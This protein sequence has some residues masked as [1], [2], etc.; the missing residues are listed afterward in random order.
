MREQRNRG[1]PKSRNRKF[2]IQT[3]LQWI[4]KSVDLDYGCPLKKFPTVKIFQTCFKDIQN[5][6]MDKNI[7]IYLNS[8]QVFSFSVLIHSIFIMH[9]SAVH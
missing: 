8:N 3:F 9:N 5:L 2:K 7:S 1:Y 6:K 4:S